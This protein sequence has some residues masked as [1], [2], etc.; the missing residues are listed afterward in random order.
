MIHRFGSATGFTV[1][2]VNA[3]RKYADLKADPI[4]VGREQKVDYVLASNYQLA[5]DR[6]SI[7][8][9]LFNVATEQ[10][11]GTYKTEKDSSNLFAMQDAVALEIGNRLLAQFATTSN[12]QTSK[13]GTTNEEAYR[14]YLQGTYLANM[15]NLEDA[16]KAIEALER[17]V[18]LDPNYARAWAGLAYAQRTLSLYG[19]GVSTHETYQKSIAAINKALALDMNLSEAHSALCENKSLF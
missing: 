4:T 7:T 17:A 5:T 13:R 1:K 11:E 2:S 14:L 19:S 3:I 6:I 12:A 9:Q 16:L 10:M 15:R 8:S 18:A